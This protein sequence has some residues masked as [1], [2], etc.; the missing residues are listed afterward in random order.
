M[1]PTF[2]SETN[3]AYPNSESKDQL[4]DY[5]PLTRVFTRAWAIAALFDK[6][7]YHHWVYSPTNF[8][9]LFASLILL[10]QPGST[11]WLMVFCIAQILDY[12]SE[13]SVMANHEIIMVFVDLALLAQA[14]RNALRGEWNHGE[15]SLVLAKILPTLRWCVIAMYFWATIHKLNTDFMN[16]EFSC[17][18]LIMH[19]VNHRPILFLFY[20]PP[21]WQVQAGIH[22]TL[23]VETLIPMLLA[24]RR[25]RALGLLMAF[26]F[27]SFLSLGF[28]NGFYAFSVVI[29][30]ILLCFVTP[31]WAARLESTLSRWLWP[32]SNPLQFF[33]LAFGV[34]LIATLTLYSKRIG[35]SRICPAWFTYNALIFAF[36]IQ[37]ICSFGLQR[38]PLRNSHA[39]RIDNLPQVVVTILFF[40]N[41]LSP[42]IGLKTENSYSMY[43]NL[44][45][46]GNRPN[47]LFIPGALSIFPEQNDLVEIIDSSVQELQTLAEANLV[48]PYFQLCS[49]LSDRP[50]AAIVFRHRGQLYDIPKV[51]DHRDKLPVVSLWKR[52][53]FPYRALERDGPQGCRH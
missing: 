7:W 1:I 36:L 16:P 50:N 24:V 11:L 29:L 2:A 10:V 6:A 33:G 51:S 26:F 42:Y 8:I 35:V 31:T 46:E 47:H 39:F 40:L 22:G 19:E 34:A 52:R 32:T 12:F 13:S 25:T 41:G 45:T 9:L 5:G 37:D 44:R 28:R 38:L 17:V 21:L 20:D 23:V 27:H 15:A 49:E 43:S 30:P 48:I 3:S 18:S 53:L 14:I 4:L